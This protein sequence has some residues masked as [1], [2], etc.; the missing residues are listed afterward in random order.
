MKVDMTAEGITSRLKEMDDLW[1]LSLK[2]MKAGRSL[3]KT[4]SGTARRAL[5]IV[6][7]IRQVFAKDWDPIGVGDEIQAVG[8]YDAYIAPVYR[9]LAGSRSEKDLIEELRRIEVDEIGVMP[10]E[11]ERLRPVAL[12]LLSLSVRLDIS[13]S[14]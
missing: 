10:S 3:P 14:V 4:K 2:L 12:K 8:E 6:D 7:S 9:I 11:V 5:R 1:L 13:E